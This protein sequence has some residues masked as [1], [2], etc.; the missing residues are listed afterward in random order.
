[1]EPSQLQSIGFT[2]ADGLA[3]PYSLEVRSAREGPDPLACLHTRAHRR[4]TG[5][6]RAAPQC[7]CR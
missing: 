7:S 6:G 4:R 3:G 5:E 2:I 1:M